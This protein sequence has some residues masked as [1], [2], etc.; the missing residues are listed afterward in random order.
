M[1]ATV[2]NEK[3]MLNYLDN[4]LNLP[5]HILKELIAKI[6]KVNPDK[7]MYYRHS[8]S[9]YAKNESTGES[10]VVYVEAWLRN[11]YKQCRCCGDWFISNLQAEILPSSEFIIY[12]QRLG[13]DVELPAC[14]ICTMMA[15]TGETLSECMY[16]FD[17]E[18]VSYNEAFMPTTHIITKKGN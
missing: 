6:S 13:R 4:R 15:D 17:C 16:A 10:V 8:D 2:N 5:L 3:T 1:Y 9:L 12:S 11:K 18:F 14:P 7:I